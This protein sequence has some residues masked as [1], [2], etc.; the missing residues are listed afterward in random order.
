MT[1][2][3]KVI[4]TDPVSCS[5]VIARFPQFFSSAETLG[6][7]DK[8]IHSVTSYDLAKPDTAV[9]LATPKTI[10]RGIDCDAGVL[11]LPRKARALAESKRGNRTVL[12][13]T[14]VEL[15]M[16]SVISHFFLKTPYTNR[17][18][19]GIHPTAIVS[20][21][22]KIGAGARVGPNTFIGANVIIGG[23]VYIGANAVIEDE[24]EIGSD[25]VIH[26]QVF[27]GHST[28][29]GQ[30]CEIHP[31]TVIGKEGFGYAHDELGNHYKIPHQGRV[32]LE[33]DVHVGSSV[34]IDR[35]TFGETRIEAGVKTDNQIHIGHNCRIG[36]NSLL[37][38]GYLM[39]GS[40]RVGA[41][42][43]AGGK[44]VVTGHINICDNVQLSAL[45]AAGKDITKPGA[46]GGVPLMP[47]REHIKMKAAMMHLAEMR[48]QVKR[49]LKHAGFESED[50]GDSDESAES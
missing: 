12:L 14:N 35:A 20:E 1:G 34:T 29:I 16:A 33:D 18:V 19:Q 41:N 21:N 31:Q 43:L 25:T 23:N 27:I 4:S 37:I 6:D 47:L 44:A 32:V 36:K 46:Y 50:P 3:S 8:T 5:A 15:A 39:A 40:S 22:A 49:L 24:A 48:K 9:F 28:L 42:F 13:A 38:A 10:S 11:V 30:R 7:L 45:S 2:S 17:S 26:P